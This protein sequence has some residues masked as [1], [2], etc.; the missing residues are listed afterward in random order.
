VLSQLVARHGGDEAWKARGLVHIVLHS[1]GRSRAARSTWSPTATATKWNLI[2]AWQLDDPDFLPRLH[3]L[4]GIVVTGSPSTLEL[5]AD[6]ILETRLMMKLR[7]ALVVLSGEP[8]STEVRHK[9]TAAMGCTVTS[10][11]AMGEVG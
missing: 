5:V 1:S 11:Y 2:R 4:S 3:A 9:V 7:P 6:R 10:A 8:V